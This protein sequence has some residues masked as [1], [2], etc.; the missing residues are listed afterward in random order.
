MKYKV[1]DATVKE[2]VE[3]KK[4][5]KRTEKAVERSRG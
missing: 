1:S 2:L 5:T 3:T 4:A